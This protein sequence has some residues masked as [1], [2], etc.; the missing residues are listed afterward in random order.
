MLIV[1]PDRLNEFGKK[2]ADTR[3][4]LSIWKSVAEKAVWKKKQDII[5]DFPKA[6]INPENIWHGSTMVFV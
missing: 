1:Y 4:S 6:K 3:K 5:Q 2:H